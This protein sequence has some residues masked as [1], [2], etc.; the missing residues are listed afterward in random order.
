M[1]T[2]SNTGLPNRV[3]HE[4]IL[5]G[6]NSLLEKIEQRRQ[7]DQ[8]AGSNAVDRSTEAGLTQY[9]S[10]SEQDERGEGPHRSLSTLS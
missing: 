1:Q 4:R 2:Q 10:S 8:R 7:L 5:A 6:I 3:L 9:R